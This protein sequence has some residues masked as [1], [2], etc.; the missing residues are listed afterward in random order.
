[1]RCLSKIHFKLLTSP[2]ASG[3]PPQKGQ[4]EHSIMRR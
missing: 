4:L 2:E 3:S 1:M